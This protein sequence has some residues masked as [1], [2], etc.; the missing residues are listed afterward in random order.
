[1]N[2]EQINN[3]SIM[4][5]KYESQCSIIEC[6]NENIKFNECNICH[7][8]MCFSH[9]H[10]I[11]KKNKDAPIICYKCMDNPIYYDLIGAFVLHFNTSSK[12]HK[13]WQRIL[14]IGRS[15]IQPQIKPL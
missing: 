1:M 12:F 14:N 6:A 7:K 9:S 15:N 3:K 13:C 10:Y 5:S 4:E 2:L 11:N 8:D